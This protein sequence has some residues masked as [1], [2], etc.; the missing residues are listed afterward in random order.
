MSDEQHRKET[1]PSKPQAGVCLHITSLPGLYGIGEIGDAACAFVDAM[2]DMELRVWQILPTGP[3]AYGDSPYQPLSTFAGNELLVDTAS[4]IRAGLLTSNEA[5]ALLSL[6]AHTVDYGAL[7]PRK[8][9]LLER[10][11]GRFEAQ[12]TAELKADFDRF[13]ERHDR[14]WLHDY[15]LFRV[16]KSRHGERAWPEWDPAFVHREE[17]A[18][19]GVEAKAARQIENIKV[20]QFLFHRQWQRL[21]EYAS[22]RRVLLFGDMPICI[23]L[24]S[25][26]AWADREMLCIDA[27]GRPERVAGVPP[28][29]FSQDGQLW[30]NPLYDWRAHAANGY[31]WWIERLRRAADLTDF[32][33]IDHFRGFEAYWSVPFEAATAR[34]GEWQPGPGD[35]VFDAMREALGHLPIIAEDLGVITPEVDA[36]RDRHRIPGMKV[37]QFEVSYE[38]FDVDKVEENCVCYTGTHD[39]DTTVGWFRGSPDDNRRPDEIA[40]TREAVI[41]VTGGSAETIHDDLTRLAFSTRARLAIAPLQD[42]LGLGSEARLN[43]PGTSGKNWRWR[44]ESEQLTPSRRA[45]IA[46]MVADAGRSGPG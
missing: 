36:L 15:A 29:Y 40:R 34:I 21:R 3:T 26:D 7:I 35:A 30:G 10:A 43:T 8:K 41:E 20:V 39:N 13:V 38:G 5:D 22:E 14:A 24:D 44:M 37:L 18:L 42:F 33:R 31:R 4:L 19:R 11:A 45:A 23:A 17:R 2:A 1:L 6:P 28:D 25:A 27:D 16:L 46:E 32:V 9:A 12:A